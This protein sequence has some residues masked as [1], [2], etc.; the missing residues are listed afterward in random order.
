[1]TA[2]PFVAAPVPRVLAPVVGMGAAIRALRGWKR[3]LLAFGAGLVSALAFAPFGFFPALLLATAVLMLLVDGTELEAR[4]VRAAAFAGW[5]FGFGQ[6]LAG[7]YWVGYAFTVD[8]A[9]HA[10]QIPLVAILL[11]GFLALY[12]ALACAVTAAVRISGSGRIFLFA[13]AYAIC[14]WLRGHLLTGFPWNVAAYAWGD[15]PQIMQSAAAVGAW[16]LT[17]LTLLFGAALADLAAP[18]PRAW[19]LPAVVAALFA[20]L[21][22][23][24]DVRLGFVN[25]GTV[26]GVRLRLVQ[27]DIPQADKMVPGLQLRNWLRLLTLSH[28]PARTAPTLI[29]WPEAAPPPFLLQRVPEALE[30]VARLTPDDRVL[31]TGTVRAAPTAAGGM[32]Y[33]NSFFIFAHGARLIGT[34]DKFHLVPFGE[35][36]PLPTLLHALGLTKV[37]NMPDGFGEGPGPRTYALPNAPPVG[38]LICY[39]IIFPGAVVGAV[40]PGWIVNVTDD[41]WFGPSTG[42]YQHLLT[43]RMRAIEEGLPVVRD[44]NTGISAIIDP[45]GRITA[46]LALDHTGVLDGALPR[47]LPRTLYAR[48]GDAGFLLLLLICFLCAFANSRTVK[49]SGVGTSDPQMPLQVEETR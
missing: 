44:A 22:I 40:R 38:P 48:L 30:Q 2:T 13:A 26:A 12:P 5:A 33:F 47:A 3:F 32:R 31:M 16:G 7:L 10:W 36:L 49:S 25:P 37:V 17:L 29:V 28:A 35:Y 15:V 8:A 14:E 27:P 1:M 18:R 23:G 6:F 45:L 20:I 24:G 42:P 39:E 34:Y 9:A 4:P 46:Q 21:W 11:P 43:A 19:I 41:S